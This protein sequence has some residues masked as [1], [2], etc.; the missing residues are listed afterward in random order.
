MNEA[1]IG[2]GAGG[3]IV[4]PGGRAAGQSG[5]DAL[6]PPHAGPFDPQPPNLIKPEVFQ[7]TA[8][9]PLRPSAPPNLIKPYLF[10]LFGVPQEL[11]PA[12]NLI[13]P[14]SFRQF[15]IPTARRPSPNLIKPDFFRNLRG[16]ALRVRPS[17]NVTGAR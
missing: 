6:R 5:P 12:A 7:Q 2:R 11:A 10:A 4:A 14:Y 15:W 13:K 1:P 8:H 17:S 16:Q 9:A 3:G